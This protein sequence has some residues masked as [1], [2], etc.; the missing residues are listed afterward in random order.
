[1]MFNLK[2]FRTALIA[3]GFIFLSNACS[4]PSISPTDSRRSAAEPQVASPSAP[5][6]TQPPARPTCLNIQEGDRHVEFNG[7]ALFLAESGLPKSLPLDDGDTVTCEKFEV[8]KNAKQPA[9]LIRFRTRET[10]TSIGISDT[11]FAVA[12]IKTGKW[13]VSPFILERHLNSETGVE[14]DEQNTIFWTEDKYG[15][16]ALTVTETGSQKS[17]TYHP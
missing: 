5:A 12:S 8:I 10:G 14:I 13:I 3:I 17:K 2:G 6:T 11:K 1:M 15:G 16:A 4:A 7:S 9:V